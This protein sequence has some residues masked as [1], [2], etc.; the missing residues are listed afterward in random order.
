MKPSGPHK[1]LLMAAALGLPLASSQAALLN[2]YTFNDGTANDSIGGQNGT[3]INPANASFSGGKLDVSANTGANFTTSAYVDLP[4]GLI[5]TAVNSGTAGTFSFS[6]WFSV[7][8]NRDWAPPLSFGTT[9]GGENG[10]TGAGASAYLQLIADTGDSANTFRLTSHSAGGQELGVSQANGAV[11]PV[12]SQISVIGVFDQSGGQP[13]TLTFYVNGVA[14]G[15]NTLAAPLD[16]STFTN[17]NNWLGRS[18]W[19]G[20]AVFDGAY[21]ELAIYDN[22]LTAQ[23]AA[24]IFAAGPVPVPEPASISLLIGGALVALRRRRA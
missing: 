17:N 12:G 1:T 8:Q 18:Q 22:A 21:D 2:L 11:A 13:G 15:S 23:E 24:A 19:N 10:N 4:N 16:L 20:D 7:S 6:L 5:T 3:V 14:V 9:D